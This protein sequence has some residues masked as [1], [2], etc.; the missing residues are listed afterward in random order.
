MKRRFVAGLI[1]CFACLFALAGCSGASS[2]S[3]QVSAASSQESAASSQE[4]A[5]SSQASDVSAQAIDPET[6]KGFWVIEP[7]SAIGFEATLNLEKNNFAELVFG[8]AYQDGTWKVEGAQ[9]IIEFPTTFGTEVKKETDEI[10]VPQS[11]DKASSESAEAASLEEA[12]EASSE[13]AEETSSEAAAVASS[14]AAS[15]EAAEVASSEAASSASADA[16]SSK[17]ADKDATKAPVRI[18]TASLDGDKL[19]LG[20][21][22]GSKLVFVKTDIVEYYANDPADESILLKSEP[23]ESVENYELMDEVV[24]AI[25]PIPVTDDDVC[26]IEIIGKGTDFIGDPGYRLAI[27]N[28]TQNTLAVAPEG[29]FKINGNEIEAI[30]GDYVDPEETIEVFL[31]FPADQ[32]GGGVEQLSNVEGNILVANEINGKQKGSYPIKVD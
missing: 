10:Y 21:E 26:K 29:A 5:A 24:E 14:E 4:S 18:A 11:A 7:D 2:S 32:L 28:K 25:T 23:S 17:A 8:D 1:V 12:D 3:S 6:V 15:S 27:T 19:V 16:A 22:N 9:V 20:Q 30:L 13:A 31:S